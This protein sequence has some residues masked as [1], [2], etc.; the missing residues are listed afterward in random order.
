MR[1]LSITFCG[2][3]RPETHNKRVNSYQQS[4]VLEKKKRYRELHDVKLNRR[5]ESVPQTKKIDSIHPL[6]WSNTRSRVLVFNILNH[7]LIDNVLFCPRLGRFNLL[8]MRLTLGKIIK[9]KLVRVE[10][11][12][13]VF[14]SRIK[15]FVHESSRE[16]IY[17]FRKGRK[18]FNAEGKSNACLCAV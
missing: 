7:N 3:L 17:F 10:F 2:S 15:V 13:R 18:T 8:P 16:R 9:I 11:F 1:T 4:Y 14:Y 12:D 5:N 6:I